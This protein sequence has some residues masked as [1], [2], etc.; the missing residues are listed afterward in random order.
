MQ[1]RELLP[2]CVLGVSAWAQGDSHP[3]A[4]IGS[5]VMPLFSK[6]GRLKTSLQKLSLWPTVAADLRWPSSTPGKP[7]V[8]ERGAMGK[9]EQRLKQLERGE[10]PRCP[11]LDGKALKAIQD[12]ETSLLPVRGGSPCK[13]FLIDFTPAHAR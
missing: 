3:A 11:W 8:A 7:P 2:G 9:L 5:A 10:L 13:L 4:L 1:I 6:K 12:I